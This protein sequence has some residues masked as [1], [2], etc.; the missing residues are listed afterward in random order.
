MEI[1]DY[2]DTLRQILRDHNGSTEITRN[3]LNSTLET[4][5]NAKKEPE[6]T[7]IPHFWFWDNA[8]NK[9]VPE[10]IEGSITSLQS[11]NT[12]TR[13][14][15][16][17]EI[18]EIVTSEVARIKSIPK[19]TITMNGNLILD[20]YFDSLDMAEIKASI[21]SKCPLSS[22]P[23]MTDLKT[24]ADIVEMA[25]GKSGN[26]EKLKECNWVVS[27]SFT[28]NP[29]HST[30]TALTPDPSPRGERGDKIIYDIISEN[31]AKL[32]DEST[33]PSLFRE[34]FKQQ[35]NDSFVYDNIL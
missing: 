13:E 34:V 12:L 4:F 28:L 7:Y 26:V 18:W 14:S 16:P 8:K 5:Y 32:G 3:A 22:N 19:E 9:I 20:Y 35:K 23:P 29:P 10:N 33:I 2:T 15:I 17:D 31:S 21:Q 30:Q 11:T 24:V 25:M 6:Q 27:K 1:Q